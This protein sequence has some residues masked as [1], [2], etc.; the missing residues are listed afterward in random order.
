MGRDQE[1]QATLVER[2]R[3]H[4]LQRWQKISSGAGDTD[5]PS[6][7]KPLEQAIEDSVN[8]Q[9]KSY[10]YVLPTQLLA[11]V[12]DPALDC[13]SVQA[14][15]GLDQAFD[16]R[17]ICQKVI[18]PFDRENQNVLGGSTEPY[19]NNPLRIPAI[20]PEFK[21]AQKNKA[22]FENLIVALDH[23]QEHPQSVPELFDRVLW[24]IKKRLN[25]TAIVYPVPNRVSIEQAKELLAEFLETRTGGL[26]LQIVVVALFECIGELF[27]LFEEIRSHRINAADASTGSV[28]DL[29]CIDREGNVVFA[30]EVKDQRLELRHIQDKLPAVREKG[31][32]EFIFLIQ[33][34]VA[35]E[36]RQSVSELVRSQFITGQNLYLLEFGPFL[37]AC[38]TLFGEAGRRKFFL[39]IGQELDRMKADFPNRKAW[40]E[41]LSKI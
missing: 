20:K 32:R 34:Q 18:V 4:L 25:E 7:P 19:V 31:I 5:F 26:R 30:I 2:C 33:G 23:A 35:A 1:T 10:R 11:K 28:A 14:D 41:I 3:Q 17:S 6:L 13:R 8:A 38:L 22:E 21:K 29:E 40:S 36:D 15:S 9:T 39:A 37:E 27:H 24:A 16:A 12:V